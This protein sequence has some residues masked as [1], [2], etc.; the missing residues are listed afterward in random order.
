MNGKSAPAVAVK[1]SLS[2]FVMGYTRSAK[3]TCVSCPGN[4]SVEEARFIVIKTRHRFCYRPGPLLALAG[5]FMLSGC[6]Q[7]STLST[8]ADSDSSVSANRKDS[9]DGLGSHE[10]G[11][12][13]TLFRW[14][15]Q[16]SGEARQAPLDEAD[17]QYAE[18][19]EWKRWQEFKAY[20]EWKAQQ[21]ASPES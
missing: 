1:T 19:L 11:A 6:A 18:Y 14:G 7:F 3:K 10:V 12:G 16:N 13:I 2:R 15:D 20:Q 21:L 8:G 5:L 9:S 17:P 4:G